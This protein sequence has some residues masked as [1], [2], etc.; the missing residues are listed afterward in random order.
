MRTVL[1]AVVVE[2]LD[3]VL[4]TKRVRGQSTSIVPQPEAWEK[5]AQEEMFRQFWVMFLK[6]TEAPKDRLC[7]VTD[8]G[9]SIDCE[10][11]DELGFPFFPDAIKSYN[12]GGGW[13]QSSFKFNPLDYVSSSDGGCSCF[14]RKLA[15]QLARA[16]SGSQH[17][18]S[19]SRQAI[20]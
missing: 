18:L 2:S 11:P 13:V 14:A 19:F 5:A 16:P 7:R 12:Q 9:N 3:A 20:L 10:L 6:F 17:S 1:P 4:S 8:G 15:R